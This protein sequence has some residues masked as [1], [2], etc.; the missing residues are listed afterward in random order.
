MDGLVAGARDRRADDR[1]CGRLEHEVGAE[2]RAAGRDDPS[3]SA[4]EAGERA[5]QR[6]G[7]EDAERVPLELE[8]APRAEE[9]RLD[10]ANRHAEH[11][12]DL[13]V[14]PTF[15]LAHDDRR[16][17]VER[18]LGERGQHLGE[19]GALLVERD[20]LGRVLEGDLLGPRAGLA[21]AHATD[22]VR[23]RDQPVVRLLRALAALERPIGV[24]ERRLRDVLGVGRVGEH[25]ERVLVDVARAPAVELLEGAV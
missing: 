20:R 25:R 10:R 23:D 11:F 6:H 9:Q 19:V 1:D 16:T 12:G 14:A 5:G 8:P 18:K 22:V 24:E 13:L 21:P 2:G 7:R 3:A 17:L 4:D 15:K